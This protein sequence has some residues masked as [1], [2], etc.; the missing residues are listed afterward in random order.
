MK[1]FLVRYNYFDVSNAK[2]AKTEDGIEK[3]ILEI[4]RE[5]YPY[6]DSVSVKIIYKGESS[7]SKKVRVFV[8]RFCISYKND[9]KLYQENRDIYVEEF[10]T[11]ELE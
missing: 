9:P 2:L 8:V 7:H 1:I 4:F 6:A 5:E 11:E 3:K 10:D